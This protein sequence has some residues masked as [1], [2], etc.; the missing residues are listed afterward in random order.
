MGGVH[1]KLYRD[2]GELCKGYVKLKVP[3]W[4][5]P[6]CSRWRQCRSKIALP[7]SGDDLAGTFKP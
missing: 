3:A 7:R 1:I 2:R 6:S 4:Q 5:L